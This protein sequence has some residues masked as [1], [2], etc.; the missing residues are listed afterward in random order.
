MRAPCAG[1]GR[2]R[3]G[4]GVVIDDDGLILTIGYLILE[5]SSVTVIGPEGANSSGQGRRL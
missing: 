4:S 5:A 3:E 2:D 1:S